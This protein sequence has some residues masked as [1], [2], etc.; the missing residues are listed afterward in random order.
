M[1]VAGVMGC[2]GI[3]H[4]GVGGSWGIRKSWVTQQG[5]CS[6]YWGSAHQIPVG[7][8]LPSQSGRKDAKGGAGLVGGRLSLL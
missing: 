1:R 2:L 3:Y 6:C 7:R 4:S 5:F 8:E